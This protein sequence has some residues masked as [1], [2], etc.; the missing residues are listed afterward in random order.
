M[1]KRLLL[2]NKRQAIF[3][4]SQTCWWNLELEEAYWIKLVIMALPYT[5][6]MPGVKNGLLGYRHGPDVQMTEPSL[7]VSFLAATAS[8]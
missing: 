1:Q 5:I 7:I 2:A 8:R 3:H 4:G 6:Y